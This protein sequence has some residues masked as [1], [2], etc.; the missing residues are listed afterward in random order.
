[1]GIPAGAAA[2]LTKVAPVVSLVGTGI[3]AFGQLQAGN[4]ADATAKYNA[5]VKEREAQALEQ[6]KIVESRRQ[7]EAAARQLSTLKL[8]LGASGQVATAG[9]PLQIIREQARQSELENLNIGQQGTVGAE[10]LRA[11]GREIRRQGKV[12]K[13]ASRIQAGSTLLTGFGGTF[14]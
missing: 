2:L 13:Q 9:T 1:M 3:S 6:Q 11:Q 12:E 8:N 14:L 7:A 5:Q 4:E 10:N